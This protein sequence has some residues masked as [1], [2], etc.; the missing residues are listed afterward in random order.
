MNDDYC[1]PTDEIGDIE[2]RKKLFDL[3]EEHRALD[4][5]IS[6]TFENNPN[7]QISLG[8]LKRQKLQLKDQIAFFEDQLR[9]D[10]IA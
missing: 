4:L 5:R 2:I 7:D 3:R 10:I 1:P 9:P 6:E 8:R